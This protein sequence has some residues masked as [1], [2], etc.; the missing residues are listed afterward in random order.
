[1][2]ADANDS[3]SGLAF[4]LAPAIRGLLASEH[5]PG[6]CIP[7][8]HRVLLESALASSSSASASETTHAVLKTV[9]E[10][11]L[12]RPCML[13]QITHLFRPI[14]IDLVA[15]WLLAVDIPIHW[16]HAGGLCPA[17]PW[18]EYPTHRHSPSGSAQK[19]D[20]NDSQKHQYLHEAVDV[21]QSPKHDSDGN[22]LSSTSHT[23]PSDLDLPSRSEML[24]A[25]ISFLLPGTPQ[26]HRYVAPLLSGI[27]GAFATLSGKVACHADADAGASPC[28]AK[29]LF[30][31]VRALYRIVHHSPSDF[32]SLF[33]WQ[34]YYLFL[35]Y[36]DTHIQIYVAETLATVLGMADTDRQKLVEPILA[37]AQD[38]SIRLIRL[39]EQEHDLRAQAE[40]FRP[41]AHDPSDPEA[42]SAQFVTHA[43]LCKFTVDLC[44]VLLPTASLD[45]SPPVT[46][47]DTADTDRLVLTPTTRR[48]LHSMGLALSLGSPILLEGGP[49]TG[50]TSLVEEASRM[51]GLSDLLKIHLGD[52]TDSKVLLGTYV[53]TS[54]PGSFR[55]QPGVLTTAVS[56][57]RWVLIED[58]DLAPM[59]V[60]S[61]LIPLLETRHLFIPSRGEKFKAKE[62]FQLFATRTIFPSKSGGGRRVKADAIGDNL[63][64][65]LKV[66]PLPIS[67]ITFILETRFPSLREFIPGVIQSFEAMSKFY[68]ETVGI[69]RYLSFRDLLKWCR[70]MSV[71]YPSI[72]P[73]TIVSGEMNMQ[74]REDLLR[75]GTDCFAGMIGRRSIVD[76]V[77]AQLGAALGIPQHRID[78]YIE[79]YAPSISTT[80]QRIVVGRGAVSVANNVTTTVQQRIR[81]ARPFAETRHALKLLERLTVCTLLNEPTLLV[82]ETGTGKTSVVQ[83][84]ATLCGRKLVVV[85]M[86]QQ[87]DSSDLL[88][89]FKPVDAKM[90]ASPIKEEFEALFA[91]TFSIKN[92]QPFLDSI[93]KAYARKNWDMLLMGFQSAVKMAEKLFEKQ[94]P[95]PPLSKK[96]KKNKPKKQLDEGLQLAWERFSINVSQFAAQRDQIQRQFLFMFVEGAL[97]KAIKE[98]HWV[99]LDEINLATS[100]TLECLSGLLQNASGS[101]LLLERGDTKPIDRHEGFRLFACM[102]PA[103]DAGKRDLPPGLRSRFTEFWVD[104]P[105]SDPLD[106]QMIVRQYLKDHL[107][108]GDMIVTDLAEFYQAAKLAS[109]NKLYD[110]AGHRVHLS[111]RTLSRALTYGVHAAAVYGL[112]RGLYEGIHMTFGTQL[113]KESKRV[114]ETLI[115]EH[116]LKSVRNRDAFLRQVPR[117]PS[118][119]G[120]GGLNHVLFESFWLEKGNLE[121]PDSIPEYVLTPSVESNLRNLARA[122]MSQKYPVLIQGPTSA[123]KTSMIEYLAKRTGHRF[124]RINNHDHT[125]LQEYLGSYVPDRDGKLVF[126]EGALVEALRR[127]YWI[128]LDELNLA[129]SD[130][131]EALNRLLDDNRE[132]LI[133][134]TQ[135]IVRPHPHFMLFATQNPPG[136]YGGRKVLSRAFRNRFLELHFDDI[137]EAELTTILEQRCRIAPSY[138]VK[139]VAAYRELMASRVKSRVFE[140]KHGFVTLRDLF[141]WAL[142]EAVGYEELAR[143][144]FMILGERCRQNDEKEVVRQAIEKVMKVK[145]SMDEYY[146]AEFSRIHS[147]HLNKGQSFGDGVVWTRAMKKLVVMVMACISNKEPTLLV[148]ETGCGKTTV[149][150]LLAR[151]SGRDLVMVNAHQHSETSD[152]LGSQRPVRGRDV[153]EREVR[154]ILNS[155][156]EAYPDLGLDIG[157][158]SMEDLISQFEGFF[159]RQ[160]DGG[161]ADESISAALGRLQ[162]LKPRVKALFEWHDGPLV[163]AMKK[164]RFFL[165]DEISLADDSVLERLNSVLEPSRLLVLA[166]KGCDSDGVGVEEIYGSEGFEFLATMNPG[167]D[168]GKKELSPALR[169]RFTEIWVPSV[170][171]QDD[172]K[173]IITS[174]LGPQAG[175]SEDQTVADALLEFIDSFSQWIHRP[176]ETVVSMRDIL[177]WVQ[178]M[179][180]SAP[181]IGWPSAFVNGGEMVIVDGIGVNPL[182]GISGGG[183]TSIELRKLCLEKLRGLVNMTRGQLIESSTFV[184]STDRW[185][186]EPFAI[187]MGPHSPKPVQFAMKA[188]TTMNN[189]KRVL[190]ALQLSKPILLEGSP[191]VGKTSLI[192]S[193]ASVTGHNLVR[194]NLSEQTDLMDLFGSDLPVEGGSGGEFAWRDGPFLRAMQMGDW[195]LLDELN[196]ASQQVLEGL[197]ACLDHRAAVYIPELD[198]TF[199]CRPGFRV[200]AAQNP[201]YQGGGRKGLPKSFVNRF[202]QVYVE[203]LTMD[204]LHMITC[205]LN[206]DIDPAILKKM[207]AFNG[208]IQDE[209]VERCLWGWKGGPWEF[210]LRDVLRWV[211]LMKSTGPGVRP[212]ISHP[213][214]Y[215]EMVFSHRM[216]TIPDRERVRS[217]YQEY[218]G[219]LPEQ[220]QRKPSWSI[221]PDWIQVGHAFLP[222]HRHRG[223]SGQVSTDHLLALHDIACPLESVMKAV[224]M[225]WMTL[226]T[227]PTA[228]GKTSLVRWL[229]A[230]TGHRLEE[231]AM[232]SGVDTVE[233]LGG[234]EQADLKRRAEGVLSSLSQSIEGVLRCLLAMGAHDSAAVDAARQLHADWDSLR[235]QGDD[236]RLDGSF[237]LSVIA[238]LESVVNQLSLDLAASGLPT[239]PGIRGALEQYQMLSQLGVHGAFEWID[240]TLLRAM[241]NGHWVM[242][243]NVNFCPASVLDRLNPLLEPNGVL[244]ISER[245]LI[246]DEVKV[247]KP[248]PD[249][250][251]FMTMDP[252]FGEVSRAMRNRAVEISLMSFNWAET[253]VSS[254]R[255][256]HT[257]ADVLTILNSLG[258]PGESLPRLVHKTHG[259][260]ADSISALGLPAN[261]APDP[262]DLV[263]FGHFVVENVQRGIALQDALENAVRDVYLNPRGDVLDVDQ[264]LITLRPLFADAQS[265]QMLSLG[266]WPHQPAGAIL[267][268]E[269]HLGRV[270]V[271]GAHCLHSMLSDTSIPRGTTLVEAAGWY[272]VEHTSLQDLATRKA[273]LRYVG[274]LAPQSYMAEFLFK[275][276][277]YEFTPGSLL[278]DIVRLEQRTAE[279]CSLQA[280][281]CSAQPVDLRGNSV[282]WKRLL[283]GSDQV[284][285]YEYGLELLHIFRHVRFRRF[286]EERVYQAS[287]TIKIGD[288]SVVQRSYALSSGRITESQLGH[289]IVRH[290]HPLFL[291]VGDMLLAMVEHCRSSISQAMLEHMRLILDRY[292]SLWLSVQSR[293]VDF[294]SLSICIKRLNKA[295]AKA[296][297]IANPQEDPL[298]RRLHQVV[299]AAART[300]KLDSAQS[301]SAIWRH[302]RVST[303]RYQDL[304]DTESKLVSLD[305]RFD[306][307]HQPLEDWILHHSLIL[308]EAIKSSIVEG[309]STLY[310]LNEAPQS[311]QEQLLRVLESVHE[312]IQAKVEKDANDLE[313]RRPQ[314]SVTTAD[315]TVLKSL[316]PVPIPWLVEMSPRLA[317]LGVL[318]VHDGSALFREAQYVGIL[319]ELAEGSKSIDEIKSTLLQLVP[320]LSRYL[321]ASLADTTRSPVSLEAW[322]RLIWIC[323]SKSLAITDD[324]LVPFLRAILQDVV[325][326]WSSALWHNATSVWLNQ[327]RN[328]RIG[329]GLNGDA[330]ALMLV[331]A[332]SKTSARSPL[333]PSILCQG[334]NTAFFVHL[335]SSLSSTPIYSFVAKRLQAQQ[336][337]AHASSSMYGRDLSSERAS[338][339]LV[340]ISSV[341]H[342]LEARYQGDRPSFAEIVLQKLRTARTSLRT[343]EAPVMMVADSLSELAGHPSASVDTP[344]LCKSLEQLQLAVPEPS[345]DKG[346]AASSKA[347]IYLG[348]AML[349][350]YVPEVPVDPAAAPAVKYRFAAESLAR[351]ESDIQVR[352]NMEQLCTGN[353]S[354]PAIERLV[355]TRREL[356]ELQTKLSARIS[357][358]PEHSQIL[359]IFSDLRVL[360]TSALSDNSI[361]SL[362]AAFD[363]ADALEVENAL[364]RELSLQE[365][366]AAYLER[367]EAKYPLYRDI[368]QPV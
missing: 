37:D 176:R 156:A 162:T 256:A 365:T 183:E 86:S 275:Q 259:S 19:D 100:E 265:A 81:L 262:K 326:K 335:L 87:S 54:T 288:L 195:V 359:E 65:K 56:E 167:G 93:N 327:I 121:I 104:S 315:D 82:G 173:A 136:L 119:G 229:A 15:R 33:E 3:L 61:V 338:L 241:E 329:S 218:F 242:I 226:L 350:A 202:T 361:L 35:K 90:L 297:V 182:Y 72:S 343:G 63:W 137:P 225:G 340:L 163:Q 94:H 232:N 314:M 14:L 355:A 204:D 258:L 150:E 101:L 166:E 66:H 189:C 268:D 348:L 247:V 228:S 177:A 164:G 27:P 77:F 11:M 208:R 148:G 6:H 276:L 175:L 158:G 215:L 144:G 217:I 187:S 96:A 67:E 251:I 114:M 174:K 200:F 281:L 334:F 36:P 102:N 354:N 279:A 257:G 40:M 12:L 201:Q 24:A 289:E 42:A 107:V 333:G 128:V 118:G 149:C 110:G 305:R 347:W 31:L 339:L 286:V 319:F 74:F 221:S 322:Q 192:S 300:L 316:Y 21:K 55:W 337:L 132:L 20:Q 308:D 2:C 62:G 13:G 320:D 356:Q 357:L 178:F 313:M 196:L 342:Y 165:L 64:T 48:N 157:A 293:D 324:G 78:F 248:H 298:Q 28:L 304:A 273:W 145:L 71:L 143:N 345:L 264:C 105:D 23:R 330:V 250:R 282:L 227:G 172:L 260:V 239:I 7:K 272:F 133:P 30:Q 1:M 284:H 112:R 122:V 147:A 303:L 302:C 312:Q 75:E 285:L 130:V 349:R 29:R 9:S 263:T 317:Q 290:L 181:N 5:H 309:I 206:P 4:L 321:A 252:K 188:P 246:N 51:T 219:E 209:V 363:S 223:R 103:N 261:M 249:F 16:Q 240:G 117:A 328:P 127:G 171:D 280:S 307:V 44:G 169:N 203:A 220:S 47:P 32:G 325:Y 154:G 186:I 283:K 161:P 49:G 50:K 191:G 69:G 124:V 236:G 212:N 146:E 277:E 222:R 294:S 10:L 366:L 184:D 318:P 193:L 352:F 17:H 138:A 255:H 306:L 235:S 131:L 76:S 358:R 353:K 60:V 98:G 296:G 126:R 267:V 34:P 8:Q 134:E 364:Q 168:Y 344:Y 83:H 207:I 179:N 323:D 213:G 25:A 292:D 135:E 123:G 351:I 362:L 185:G 46:S 91:H 95:Q 92:N 270:S 18:I 237:V 291:Y 190:R 57:G 39:L 233:L 336:L 197:N 194:I 244:L 85:N 234:F 155:A 53:C 278:D 205:S 271:D 38:D 198:R 141:R 139:L 41:P 109:D 332:D 269:S 287:R 299:D 84:L 88:G 210:N 115:D 224:E 70:R 238:S 301:N 160:T 367:M 199:E 116:L 80:E 295:L 111:I 45:P 214:E 140:G 151:A 125:D 26:I 58:I 22:I 170:T 113:G 180:V 368:L 120:D 79:H 341:I 152:F 231:F 331:D 254:E 89:G 97:V 360:S 99:L 311:E 253:D 142:R 274:G 216:R 43:D 310:Y 153:I 346:K 243:D 73:D 211:E 68:G 159:S 52:Q 108:P 245:G 129:P 230:V 59:E 266:R 106:L